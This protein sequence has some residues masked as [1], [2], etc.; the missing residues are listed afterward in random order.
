MRKYML[1]G[2]VLCWAALGGCPSAPGAGAGGGGAGGGGAGGGGASGGDTSGGQTGGGG[3]GGGGGSQ[4]PASGTGN[5]TGSCADL[6]GFWVEQGGS[7][8]RYA[9]LSHVGNTLVST[10]LQP[11]ICDHRDGTGATSQTTDDFSA[12]LSGCQF[13]GSLSVCQFGCTDQCTNGWTASDTLTGEASADGQK[14]TAT[15]MD[16]N[17]NVN[18][19][20]LF[21]L[22]CQ[23]K[24]PG[25]YGLPDSGTNQWTRNAAQSNTPDDGGIGGGV[26]YAPQQSGPL[27]ADVTVTAGVTEGVVDTVTQFSD[28]GLNI[29]IRHEV[30]GDTISFQFTSAQPLISEG[31]VISSASTPI[32]QIAA[33][34][35]SSSFTVFGKNADGSP[36]SPDCFDAPNFKVSGA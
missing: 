18:D 20:T 13:S 16:M 32:A 27:A 15:W 11:A 3:G 17:G 6:A 22:L 5:G 36:N 25:D 4:T 19:F 8:P 30:T 33:G 34:T 23:P 9:F 14:I 35:Q 29:V 26:F 31:Q 28:G 10:F 21:R 24:L 2:L 12:T 1:I 7:V